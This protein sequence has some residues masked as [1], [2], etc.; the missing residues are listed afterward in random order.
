S[1]E[2]ILVYFNYDA[3]IFLKDV[4]KN[5]EWIDAFEIDLEK[6]EIPKISWERLGLTKVSSYQYGHRAKSFY[7]I[8]LFDLAKEESLEALRISPEDVNSY[9]VLGKIA[10]QDKEYDQA[11]IYLRQARMLGKRSL[12]LTH[13]IIR[14]YMGKEMFEKSEVKCLDALRS[15]PNH[16]TMRLLLVE[17][18]VLQDRY[19]H[20][21][22]EIDHID[23]L[24]WMNADDLMGIADLLEEKKAY[25][26]AKEVY[27]RVVDLDGKNEEARKA[28]S[29]MDKHL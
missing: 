29:Q 16:R 21:L 19:D 5:K 6:W 26:L 14:S 1:E 9:H 3:I 28:V 4:E 12:E 24:T 7:N 20:V 11:Y 18:H 13:D 15:K 17:I 22:E 27:Q 25:G 10:L 23:G 8:D 2:W